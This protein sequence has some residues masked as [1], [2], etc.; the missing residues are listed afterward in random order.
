MGTDTSFKKQQPALPCPPKA[1]G[2]LQEWD[3]SPGQREGEEG[4]ASAYIQGLCPA[5]DQRDLLGL[6]G[7]GGAPSH[8]GRAARGLRELVQGFLIIRSY[9]IGQ[10][11]VPEVRGS[12]GA[13]CAQA[14]LPSLS[15]LG[16]QRSSEMSQSTISQ[17][18]WGNCTPGGLWG[19]T[20]PRSGRAAGPALESPDPPSGTPH[21]SG[22][23]HQALDE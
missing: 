23:R 21:N 15:S 17:Y 14:A 5:T 10:G 16:A 3:V 8:R 20:G 12:G 1:C 9:K 19:A 22:E 7:W 6:A 2:L 11:T 18:K 13:G 4:E